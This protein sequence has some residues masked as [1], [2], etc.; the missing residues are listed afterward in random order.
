MNETTLSPLAYDLFDERPIVVCIHAFPCDRRMWRRQ[1]EELSQYV[2]IL[3]L[4]LP[5]FGDSTDVSAPPDLDV[6]ADLVNTAIG[7]SIGDEP[8]VLCGL[9]MGGY[10]ALRLAARHPERLEALILADTRAGADTPEGI[11]A[12]NRAIREIRFN[13]V[14]P[15]A[16]H[17]LPRLLSPEA[18][19][20]EVAFARELI[21]E[22]N[23]EAVIN[24][25][26]AMRDRPDSTAVLSDIHVPTL[27]IVGAADALTPP[28]DAEA[29]ARELEDVWLVKIPA[30]GHLSNLE[31]P[32]Q[33]NMAVKGF[34]ETL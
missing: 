11:D 25:L 31:A 7:Q 33:F 32:V 19:P 3:T 1:I 13:G 10:V 15:L 18:D 4:D 21:L 6:W 27:I 2:H 26:G 30:T 12:R 23:P 16:E 9:S 17:L 22:Q 28:A 14:A 5:G 24:A 29:M 20:E 8:A 34:L